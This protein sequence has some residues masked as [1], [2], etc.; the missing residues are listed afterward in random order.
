MYNIEKKI[1]IHLKNRNNNG[2]EL[3]SL[4]NLRKINNS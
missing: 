2:L 1:I 4:K 3:N